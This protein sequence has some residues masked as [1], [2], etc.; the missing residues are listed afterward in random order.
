MYGSIY[1][2]IPGKSQPERHDSNKKSLHTTEVLGANLARQDKSTSRA[3]FQH[4][5]ALLPITSLLQQYVP[6]ADSSFAEWHAHDVS[7]CERGRVMRKYREWSGSG[8]GDGRGEWEGAGV[9][10]GQDLFD[11]RFC[12]CANLSIEHFGVLVHH[13]ASGRSGH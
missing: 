1:G 10:D 4:N 5:V 6:R 12:V 11:E 2:E 9:Q 7:P 13:A 8:R 3:A